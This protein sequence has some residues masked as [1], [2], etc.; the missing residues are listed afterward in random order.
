MQW[1]SD[2]SKNSEEYKKEAIW[3]NVV[4]IKKLKSGNYLLKLYH[5]IF[6]KRYLKKENILELT[7]A[8]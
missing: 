2:I 5:L 6:W 7:L 4:Y 1:N 8:I 3:N